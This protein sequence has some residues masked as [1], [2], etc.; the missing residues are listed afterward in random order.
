MPT[1]K[2]KDLVLSGPIQIRFSLNRQLH[3][4]WV[5]GPSRGYYRGWQLSVFFISLFLVL[6]LFFFFSFFPCSP[7]WNNAVYV[8]QARPDLFMR[9]SWALGLRLASPHQACSL[10]HGCALRFCFVRCSEEG[11]IK[12]LRSTHMTV[13]KEPTLL[14]FFLRQ[15][16]YQN[17]CLRTEARI[18]RQSNRGIPE[19]SLSISE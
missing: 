11:K 7:G 14:V 3:D 4:S 2:A 9:L 15:P 17:A 16:V 19:G 1:G 6:S 8:V 12:I 13:C 10:E 18:L 5:C